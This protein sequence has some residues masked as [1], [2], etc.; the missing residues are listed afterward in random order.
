MLISPTNLNFKSYDGQASCAKRAL[1]V[2]VSW[3]AC[4]PRVGGSGLGNFRLHF[5]VF[6]FVQPGPARTSKKMMPKTERPAASIHPVDHPTGIHPIHRAPALLRPALPGTPR[7][8][9]PAASRTPPTVLPTGCRRSPMLFVSYR[10]GVWSCAVGFLFL[11]AVITDI[12]ARDRLICTPMVCSTTVT[13]F[14]SPVSAF[15]PFSTRP[16]FLQVSVGIEL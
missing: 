8:V 3:T 9:C 16:H 12:F 7:P 1:T 14:V 15:T 2:M 11:L 10:L 6:L 5:G 13:T 4:L